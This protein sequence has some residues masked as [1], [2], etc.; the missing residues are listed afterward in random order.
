MKVK[1]GFVLREFLSEY[2]A[3]PIENNLVSFD[4]VLRLNDEAAFAF[5]LLKDDISEDQL[6]SALLKKYPADAEETKADVAQFIHKLKEAG[7]I[8]GE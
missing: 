4:G 5:D 6:V 1:D 8:E 3:I 7:V 2:I